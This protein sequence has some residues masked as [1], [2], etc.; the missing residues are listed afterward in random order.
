M[1][2]EKGTSHFTEEQLKRY[3]DRYDEILKKGWREHKQT[4]GKYAQKEEKKIL[5]RLKKYKRNHHLFLY[6]FKVPF[7][8]NMSERD[9]RK[10]K[11]RQKMA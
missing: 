10:C 4:K 9:L 5:N 1:Q 2:T 8:D 6:N 3:S 7:S 11:N